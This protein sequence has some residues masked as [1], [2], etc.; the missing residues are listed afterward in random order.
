M[1]KDRWIWI[2]NWDG[3][4]GFQ[5]YK[6]RDPIWIKNYTRLLSHDAYTELSFAQRGLLHG[7]WLEYARSSRK[8]PGNT[9]VLSRRLGHQVFHRSLIAL[10]EAGFIQFLDSTTLAKR[11][12]DASPEKNR[13]EKKGVR[14]RP[15]KDRPANIVWQEN[16]KPPDLSYITRPDYLKAV[17]DE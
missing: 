3:T 17:S 8:L 14:V 5:H 10:S 7:L 4:D 2:P 11:L 1:S 13:E 16:D 15:S 6:G 12:Q 9:R